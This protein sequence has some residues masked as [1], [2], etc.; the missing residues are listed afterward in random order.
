MTILV[1][2]PHPDDE[3]LGCGGTLLR[4]KA[5]GN[6]IHWLIMTKIT[7]EYGYSSERIDSRKNEI[8]EVASRYGFSSV[9]QCDFITTQLDN[10]PKNE[11]IDEVAKTINRIQPNTVYVPFRNDIHSDHAAVFDAVASCS[12]SFRYP[13][14]R[15]IR[16]YETLSESEFSLH[17]DDSGF[18]PNL[19][20]DV[21]SYL[22][23]KI[24]IMNIYKGEMG[25]HPFPRS[26]R[27]IRALATFRGA[28]VGVDSAES[29]ISLKEIL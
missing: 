25:E 9:T 7:K 27:N 8:D 15:K 18:K 23:K 10:V 4:H 24:E 22:N 26:E 19:W 3:T 21:S 6:D 17:P 12:K 20:V 5:E 13:S 29:F 16:A 1:V 11:L 14:I 2:A 28:T